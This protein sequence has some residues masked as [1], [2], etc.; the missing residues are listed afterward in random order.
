MSTPAPDVQ[1]S[2]DGSHW[3]N[4]QQWLPVAPTATPALAKR[5]SSPIVVLVLVLLAVGIF[6]GI[7]AVIAANSSSGITD[8]EVHDAYCESFGNRS[9][10][11]SCP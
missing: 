3:W 9:E 5:K 2:P 6:G 11:P 7:A 1:Y 8:Q 10:D 4:G